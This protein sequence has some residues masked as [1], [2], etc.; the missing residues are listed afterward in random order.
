M[1]LQYIRRNGISKDNLA[2]GVILIC[3]KNVASVEVIEVD[4]YFGNGKPVLRV[5]DDGQ[6]PVH[7]KAMQDLDSGEEI[8]AFLEAKYKFRNDE[9]STRFRIMRDERDYSGALVLSFM[10]M[11]S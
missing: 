1:K 7:F 4:G 8:K 6:H 5:A 9:T 11:Y 3:L 10:L 2:V